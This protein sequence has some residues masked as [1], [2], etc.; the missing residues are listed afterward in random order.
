MPTTRSRRTGLASVSL[1]AASAL[2]IAAAPALHDPTPPDAAG[3]S[4]A[5]DA[6]NPGAAGPLPTDRP[7]PHARG[8]AS[9]EAGIDRPIDPDDVLRAATSQADASLAAAQ[10]LAGAAAASGDGESS[11]PD[12]VDAPPAYHASDGEVIDVERIRTWLEN[13]DAPLAAYAEELVEAGIT[14]DVDPRLVVAIATMESSAGLRLPPGSHN[15]WGWGGSGAHG[16]HHW[17]SWEVAIDDYTQRLGRL[18]D[19]EQVDETFARTY[20]PPEW[21]RWLETVTWV[22]G[23]I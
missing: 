11:V 7:A 3:S 13:R 2:A 21:R 12:P 23:D 14:H 1:L 6:S 19:T 18:Y 16:L 4:R 20:C 10:L 15:A 17:P 22:I 8:T 5:T 9:P